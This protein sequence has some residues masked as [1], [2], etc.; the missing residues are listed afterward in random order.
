MSAESELVTA[1]S[2]PAVVAA[3]GSRVYPDF[4]PESCQYPAAIYA[5]AATQ[6]VQSIAGQH[7]GDFVDFQISIWSKPPRGSLDAAADVVEMALRTAGHN[8]T[9]RDAGVDQEM[10]LIATTITVQVLALA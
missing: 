1:L 10:G 8:V 9:G 7:F 5:R 3:L 2:S 4:L 6:P